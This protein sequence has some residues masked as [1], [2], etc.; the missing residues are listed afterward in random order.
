MTR[1]KIAL[2]ASLLVPI[3]VHGNLL[4]DGSFEPR[5]PAIPD[6]FSN[7]NP[8][9]RFINPAVPATLGAWNATGNYHVDLMGTGY[10]DAGNNTWNTAYDGGQYLYI[11]D[12]YPL[13][14]GAISQTVGLT[15][16]LA[17]R[18]TFAQT[19]FPNQWE[20]GSGWVQVTV[21][22]GAFSVSQSF[23]SGNVSNGG[24]G[25]W[26]LRT[27]DFTLPG[28]SDPA[29]TT[30]T[31]ASRIGNP[32]IIDAVNLE[33]VAVPEAGTCAAAALLSLPLV[34]RTFRR[35]LG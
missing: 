33:A 10:L 18:L 4:L 12:S 19:D 31:F 32:G 2:A 11:S 27:L 28:P 20:N 23:D 1:M 25:D 35:R 34:W 29:T 3:A 5:T 7:A 22:S 6:V 9:L 17:Y 30:V 15:G 16:G 21:S 24:A 26:I 14:A 8:R 13:Y